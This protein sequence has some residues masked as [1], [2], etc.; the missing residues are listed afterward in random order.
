MDEIYVEIDR[1]FKSIYI[2]ILSNKSFCTL[3]IIYFLGLNNNNYGTSSSSPPPPSTTTTTA[4]SSIPVLFRF[5]MIKYIIRSVYC[6]LYNRQEHDVP[7]NSIIPYLHASLQK[8]YIIYTL[9]FRSDIY[10][11][12]C[13]Y[14][15]YNHIKMMKWNQHLYSVLNQL[16][17]PP[18]PPKNPTNSTVQNVTS[19]K[20]VSF[21]DTKISLPL[22]G[23]LS[24]HTLKDKHKHHIS[25]NNSKSTNNSSNNKRSSSSSSSSSTKYFSLTNSASLTITNINLS[26]IYPSLYHILHH[27][28]LQLLFNLSCH[29]SDLITTLPSEFLQL[30]CIIFITLLQS[31]LP[32]A[33]Q[34]TVIQQAIH[35]IVSGEL[36][37]NL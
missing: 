34:H 36:I 12:S 27:T 23:K 10:Q 30:I 7:I 33:F 18:Q 25:N 5:K 28:G 19:L 20:S 17:T 1:V 22:H 8:E 24:N 6:E 9:F 37:D 35:M 21:L 13:S 15:I 16:I 2:Y 29:L 4:S 32:T 14:I 31:H 3:E 26:I 11:S